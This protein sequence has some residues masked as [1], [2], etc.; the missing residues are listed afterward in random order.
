L[1]T[2]TSNLGTTDDTE[3]MNLRTLVGRHTGRGCLARDDRLR[4][5]AP[6]AKTAKS[7]LP[8]LLL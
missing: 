7:P 1:R 2:P 5:R 6:V 3:M 8:V 4:R